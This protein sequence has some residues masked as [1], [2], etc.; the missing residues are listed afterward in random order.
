MYQF[1]IR[2]GDDE[3]KDATPTAT[4]LQKK[5]TRHLGEKLKMEKI[6]TIRGLLYFRRHFPSLKLSKNK[7]R[8]L[9]LEKYAEEM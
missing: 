5:L 7:V 6:D 2:D 3:F 1:L 4:H 8:V 9:L